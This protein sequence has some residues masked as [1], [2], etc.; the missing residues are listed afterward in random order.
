MK[1]EMKQKQEEIQEK[2]EARILE[3]KLDMKSDGERI[4]HVF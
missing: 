1:K 4:L 3:Q 2:K